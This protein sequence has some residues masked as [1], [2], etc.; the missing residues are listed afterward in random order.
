MNA[1]FESVQKRLLSVADY[2]RMGEAGIFSLDERIELIEGE[3]ITVP[4]IGPAHAGLVAQLTQLLLAAV[5]DRAI[6]W[7]QN[8]VR[9]S[10]LSEPEPDLALLRP[11]RDFYRSA[12]PTPEDTLLAIEVSD[13]TLRYDRGIK[14]PLYARHGVPEVWLV[15]VAGERLLESREPA[16]GGYASERVVDLATPLVPAAL[17]STRIDL[18]SLFADP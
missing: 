5:E 15:D 6:V 3:I 8:P 18:S 9:L 4:P 12:H 17:P 14:V 13:S 2:H 11:R 1:A 7:A 10:D 16:D